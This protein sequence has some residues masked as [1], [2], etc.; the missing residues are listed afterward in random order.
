MSY[1]ENLDTNELILLANDIRHD[2]HKVRDRFK[3]KALSYWNQSIASSYHKEQDLRDML[4]RCEQL[5]RQ[6]MDIS[7]VLKA[8]GLHPSVE[9][10]RDKDNKLFQLKDILHSA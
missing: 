4:T 7:D 3:N 10:W 9:G 1:L 8:R 6:Y 2:Y 5:K